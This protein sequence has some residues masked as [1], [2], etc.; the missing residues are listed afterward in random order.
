MYDAV[1][2]HIDGGQRNSVIY[3]ATDRKSAEVCNW[4]AWQGHINGLRL[5]PRDGIRWIEDGLRASRVLEN[6]EAE[7]AHLGNLASGYF[8]LGDAGKAKEYY[9][10]EAEYILRICGNYYDYCELMEND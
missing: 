1:W 7:R 2:P 5:K 9:E 4:Y 3:L 8:D 10:Q 6:K